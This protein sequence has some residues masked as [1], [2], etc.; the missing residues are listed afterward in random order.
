MHKAKPCCS[1]RG[2]KAR[3]Q[4]HKSRVTRQATNRFLSPQRRKACGFLLLQSSHSSGTPNEGARPET[5][6]NY[7]LKHQKSG[8]QIRQPRQIC[9]NSSA[10]SQDKQQLSR[11]A[12]NASKQQSKPRNKN[13]WDPQLPRRVNLGIVDERPLHGGVGQC[14]LIHPEVRAKVL[15]LSVEELLFGRRTGLVLANPQAEQS[16]HD[17]NFES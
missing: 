16:S 15:Q 5:F 13:L 9:S 10:T 8:R 7:A 11:N 3:I 17:A 6:S 14:A 12:G 2:E 4:L 1:L